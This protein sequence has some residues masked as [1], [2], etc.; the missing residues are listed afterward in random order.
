MQGEAVSTIT[1][2]LSQYKFYNQMNFVRVKKNV[3][4][5]GHACYGVATAGFVLPH[6]KRENNTKTR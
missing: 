2:S 5:D 3:L 1:D 4:G 6:L